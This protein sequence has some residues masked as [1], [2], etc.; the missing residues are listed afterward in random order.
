MDPALLKLMRLQSRALLRRLGR[1]LRT[2]RGAAFFALGLAVFILWI[3]PAVWS[4]S[5]QRAEPAHVRAVVP[6]ILLAVVLLSALSGA[7][8]KAIAF[9]PGEVDF[10]FP[11][12]FRR[13]DLL[14]Y[15]LAKSTFAA[16]FSALILSVALLRNATLWVACFLGCFLSLL[17]VQF[18]STALVLL[19]QAVSERAYTRTRKAMLAVLVVLAALAIRE[20]LARHNLSD[21]ASLDLHGAIQMLNHSTAGKILLAPTGVFSQTLT[22]ERIFPDLLNWGLLALLINAALLGLIVKL[23]ANYLEAAAG[24]SQRRYERLRRFQA[25]G[26]TAMS[27]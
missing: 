23:D 13:R 16:L 18:F 15:K 5:Q 12:P 8:D 27:E 21:P 9:T 6:L 19:G 11:G 4:A 7:G 3:G 24:A 17:F 25:G 22:A 20:V 2:F 26:V 10:L 1:G 14:F